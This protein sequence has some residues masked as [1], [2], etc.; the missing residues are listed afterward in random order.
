MCDNRARFHIFRCC[1]V[2]VLSSPWNHCGCL[3]EWKHSSIEHI[4]FFAMLHSAAAVWSAALPLNAEK[5]LYSGLLLCGSV[6]G[7]RRAGLWACQTRPNSLADLPW[8]RIQNQSYA[9]AYCMRCNINEPPF[10]EQWEPDIRLNDAELSAIFIWNRTF[11]V[12]VCV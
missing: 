8:I 9:V 7:A 11:V 12:R 2:V 1:L 6:V 3:N 5:K 4:F 10:H